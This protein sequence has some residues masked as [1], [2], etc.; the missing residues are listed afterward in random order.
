MKTLGGIV[1]IRNGNALDYCW[2]EAIK[3]LLP[4]CD[5]VTVCDG[6]STDGTQ[7]EIRKWM[8]HE[9]KIVL[10]VYPWPDP[11]GVN[12]F[13]VDWLQYARAHTR[14]DY[15]LQLDADEILGDNSYNTVKEFTRREG[16]F[17]VWCNR[18]NFWKD[19]EHTIPHG[20]CLGHRV[21]R[22]LPQNVYLPSDG[23]VPEGAEA[24]GMAVD[25]NIEIFHYGFIRKQDAFFRKAKALQKFFFNSYDQRLLD[26]E[27]DG[28]NWMEHKSMPEWIN[29]L[30]D[31]KGRH[32]LV[33]QSWLIERGYKCT[34]DEVSETAKYRYLTA[35]YCRTSDGRSGVGVDIGSQGDTVVPWAISYDLP[36]AEFDT[37]C[38]FHPPKGPI[39]L[40]GH[41]DK[42]PFD[43]GSLDFVYSSHLLEDYLDWNPVLDEWVRVL[44]PGG[45][46]I[47]LVPD[48]ELWA[49]AMAKGQT[50]NC[51]HRHEARVGEL[52]T[53][54][55]R[56]GLRVLEDRLTEVNPG[57]YTILF[58]AQKV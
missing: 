23:S 57:D 9:P 38:S 29:R 13:W 7:E 34:R 56:L 22:M 55:E 49:A 53:Y 5:T 4:V 51:A 21:I 3:S 39:H 32:P 14:T 16:R 25:S 45:N 46:L 10:C 18:L 15:V 36:Q 54:A 1:C 28:G 2:R 19:H 50:P 41:G 26:A 11:V 48:K 43:T 47:V 24:V 44:K 30:V 27:K 8:R 35:K 20:V 31:F 6:E 40:R 12:N 52:S 58:A 17:S 37:Y 42:L 33:I